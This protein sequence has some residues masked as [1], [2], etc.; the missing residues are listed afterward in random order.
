MKVARFRATYAGADITRIGVQHDLFTAIAKQ[1]FKPEN[2]LKVNDFAKIFA[3][4]VKTD[5]SVGNIAWYAGELMSMDVSNIEFLTMPANT[6]DYLNGLSGCMIYVDEWLKMLN[7]KLNPYDT[8]ITAHHIN[9]I[10]RDANGKAYATNGELA[11]N[12]IGSGGSGGT[13]KPSSSTPKPSAA[14]SSGSNATPA[15]AADTPPPPV[16]VPPDY[17]PD[18]VVITPDP[19]LMYTPPP[20]DS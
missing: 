4:N 17:V 15:P 14:A 11:T 8:E 12:W 16:A 13:P 2:L 1:A 18:V 20:Q 5:L 19:G 6:N 3:E 10:G 7:E 9:V